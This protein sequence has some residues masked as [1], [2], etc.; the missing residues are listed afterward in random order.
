MIIP[1][2]PEPLSF[3]DLEDQVADHFKYAGYPPVLFREAALNTEKER[4]T[5]SVRDVHCSK[6][7]S[8]IIADSI[9]NRVKQLD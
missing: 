8:E 5:V 4:I 9:F 7:F 3:K 1:Y 2:L 6:Y